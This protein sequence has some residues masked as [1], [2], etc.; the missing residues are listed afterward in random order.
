[1]IFLFT[2][3]SK[4]K[5]KF[6]P[7]LQMYMRY[8]VVNVPL[9]RAESGAYLRLT[10]S[11]RRVTRAAPRPPAAL[12]GPF[13]AN[14]RIWTYYLVPWCSVCVGGLTQK[15]KL[16]AYSRQRRHFTESSRAIVHAR[17]SS[18]YRSDAVPTVR[19]RAIRLQII[20]IFERSK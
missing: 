17:H 15:S 7:L 9:S 2:V 1:M 4:C 5:M 12:L 3:P 11:H 14:C 19:A 13:G 8:A 6:P 18:F 10:A 16:I 20:I